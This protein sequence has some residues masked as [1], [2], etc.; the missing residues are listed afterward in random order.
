MPS[1][2]RVAP[3][4]RERSEYRAPDSK[5]VLDLRQNVVHEPPHVHNGLRRWGPAER[6]PQQGQRQTGIPIPLE[7]LSDLL[8]S[9]DQV[10]RQLAA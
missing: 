1:R 7:I 8:G 4:G 6:R 10:W 9:A 3:P 5:P 2:E